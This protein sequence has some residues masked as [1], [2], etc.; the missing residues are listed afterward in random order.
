MLIFNIYL[1]K[2]I[3]KYRIPILLFIIIII[4][5]VYEICINYLGKKY[6]EILIQQIYRMVALRYIAFLQL[7]IILYYNKKII[8]EKL[9]YILP[10]SI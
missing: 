9:K 3:K 4:E 10:L 8:L 6:N 7:G 5:T 1:N 2:I